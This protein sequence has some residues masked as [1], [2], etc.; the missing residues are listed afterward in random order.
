[1]TVGREGEEGGEWG[2]MEVQGREG[3]ELTAGQCGPPVA[4]KTA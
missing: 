4:V 2:V 1:M 3:D